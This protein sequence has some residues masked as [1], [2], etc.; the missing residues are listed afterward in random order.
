LSWFSKSKE[1]KFIENNADKLVNNLAHYCA[2]GAKEV[3]EALGEH[4]PMNLNVDTIFLF[5]FSLRGTIE[6]LGVEKKF[7]KRAYQFIVPAIERL[8]Q[9]RFPETYSETGAFSQS[10]MMDV[11]VSMRQSPDPREWIRVHAIRTLETKDPENEMF[12]LCLVKV[13]T[14][15]QP[16]AAVVEQAA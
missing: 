15:G 2:A 9:A 14:N 3:V 6:A 16:I 10:L 11:A 7:G 5:L 8:Y 4:V 12:H 1:E 13:F